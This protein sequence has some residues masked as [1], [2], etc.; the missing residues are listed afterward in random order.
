[1]NREENMTFVSHVF[2]VAKTIYD[3]HRLATDDGGTDT[4]GKAWDRLGYWEREEESHLYS[5]YE[6]V[7]TEEVRK[8]P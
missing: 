2:V 4:I 6:V 3:A 8:I 1:M 5:V 7:R